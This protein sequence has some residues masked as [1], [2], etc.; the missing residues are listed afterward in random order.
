MWSIEKVTSPLHRASVRFVASGI[1][2]RLE[3]RLLRANL[4]EKRRVS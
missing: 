3:A 4:P 1:R 2:F